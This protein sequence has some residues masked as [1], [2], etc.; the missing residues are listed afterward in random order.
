MY[1]GRE[2][3]E[4]YGSWVEGEQVTIDLRGRNI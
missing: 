1:D 3:Q 2:F 4:F